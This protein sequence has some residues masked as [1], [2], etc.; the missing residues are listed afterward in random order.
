MPRHCEAPGCG[1]ATR[2]GKPFCS[3]H[4]ERHPYIARLVE[5]LAAREEEERLVRERGVAAVASDGLTA[6]EILAFL[7]V[8]GDRS[9]PRLARDLNMDLETLE[10][11]VDALVA[12]G[13]LAERRR[14][15]RARIVGLPEEARGPRR[16][17]ARRSTPDPEREPKAAAG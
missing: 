17:R 16:R 11:Y 15:R 12:R 5:Q 2:A 14:R 3:E 8:H 9:V 7:R 4:V 13:L 6:A 10:L 1:L